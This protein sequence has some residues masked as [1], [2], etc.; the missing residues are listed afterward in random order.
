M[1]TTAAPVRGVD[2][3]ASSVHVF[4]KGSYL[5]K[6]ESMSKEDSDQ[7]CST[8]MLAQATGAL[9]TQRSREFRF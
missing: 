2:I 7:I 6:R 8:H 3:G 4:D 1:A 9:D 5:E